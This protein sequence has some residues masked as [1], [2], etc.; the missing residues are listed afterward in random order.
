MISEI[1]NSGCEEEV[2][3]RVGAGWGKWREMCATRGCKLCSKL[4]SISAPAEPGF[5]WGGGTRP[6]PHRLASV[7]HTFEAVAGSWGSVSAPAVSSHGWS[8][9]GEIKIG[10]KYWCNDI[11]GRV[12][13]M[14]ATNTL[15]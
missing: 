7:V 3:H 10:K 4:H 11:W 15:V 6:T 5:L 8:P 13:V 14:S 2:R 12:F 9:Q 1:P